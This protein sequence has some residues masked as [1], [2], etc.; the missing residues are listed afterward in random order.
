MAEFASHGVGTAGLT[1]GIIGTSLAGLLALNA[2]N[3]GNGG[4]LGGLL[5]GGNNQA[6]QGAM[7]GLMAENSV[8][9]SEKYTDAAVISAYEKSVAQANVIYDRIAAN[10]KEAFVAIAALDKQAAVNACHVD[11]LEKTVAKLA[12]EACNQKAFNVAIQGELRL[13]SERRACGDENLKAYVDGTFVP[14]K[15]IMPLSSICP[16]AQPATKA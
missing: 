1:T 3:N 10:Q 11:Q 4:L 8:L 12:D 14:G 13:E 6:Q 7:M 2:S 16:P 5:G 15:L 9:K